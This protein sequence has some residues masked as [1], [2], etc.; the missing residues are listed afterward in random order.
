LLINSIVL[1]GH[2]RIFSMAKDKNEYQMFHS[3]LNGH[4]VFTLNSE[5][6]LAEVRSKAQYSLSTSER[7]YIIHD[8]SDIRKA[9]SESLEY[10]GKVQSLQKTVINGYKT[11]NSVAIDP[12]ESSVDLLEHTTYST[13]HPDFITEDMVKLYKKD[14]QTPLLNADM[15]EKIDKQAYINTHKLFLDTVLQTHNTFK[16]RH[17]SVILTHIQ[18]REFDGEEYFEFITDLGD[19]LITR[20]KL[21]RL[22]NERQLVYTPKTNKL[23]KKIKYKPLIDKEFEHKSSY[24]IPE[25]KIKNKKYFKVT[26]QIEWEELILNERTYYCVKINLLTE[27]NK[28]IFEQPMLLITNRTIKTAQAAKNVYH[29]YLMRT[30]IEVVFKFL[31]QNLGW[32][33]FQVRDFQSIKNLLALAFYLAAHFDELKE[34]IKNH[35]ISVFLAQLG[36]G[37]GIVS[38]FFILK[39][40]EVIINYQQVQQL[41]EAGQISKQQ[42]DDALKHFNYQ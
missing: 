17:K 8:P 28:P 42:I 24:L 21:S 15:K 22:S 7:I 3:L 39:G 19:E 36:K 40:L 33:T 29:A 4:H 35:E 26:C 2:L 32:E 13:A 20:L 37:K 11:F 6:L 5:T 34:N 31:K 30:K 10:L 18:D 38:Q 16:S 12:L 41:I 25:L 27:A 23:S 14:P 1:T 9:H